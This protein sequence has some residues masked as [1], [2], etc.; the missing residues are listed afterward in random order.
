MR[1]LTAIDDV[2]RVLREAR[3]VAVLGAHR[4]PDKPAHYV[5]D[6]LA[7]VGYEVLPVN[8]A[9]AHTELWGTPVKATLAE[10][11]RP[12]DVVDVF[13]RP[14]HLPAHVADILAMRPRPKVV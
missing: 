10:L 13:R 6:Y 8:P 2:K 12:I 9:F 3:T 4:D 1:V 11:D 7:S 5:P 14:E